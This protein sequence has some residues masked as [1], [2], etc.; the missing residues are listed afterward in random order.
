[1]ARSLLS[2]TDIGDRLREAFDPQYHCNLYNLLQ[3]SL[4]KDSGQL[5]WSNQ[6]N[7]HVPDF[8]N[9]VI[10][11]LTAGQSRRILQTMFTHLSRVG[12]AEP[13]PEFGKLNKWSAEL[14]KQIYLKRSMGNNQGL[15]AF[16]E[17]NAQA[18]NEG[19][20]LGLGFV[21]HMLKTN[22]KT[23]RQYVCLEHTPACT[24]F[25]DRHV[26]HPG[27]SDFICFTKYIRKDRAYERFGKSKVE[28]Y[29]HAYYGQEGRGT[30]P[31][32]AV[33]V[34]EY[35]DIGSESKLPTRAVIPE[36]FSNEPLEYEENVFELLPVSWHIHF[37]A[38]M[39]RRPIGRV[40]MQTADEEILNIMEGWMTYVL[41]RPAF[42]AVDLSSVDARSW[43]DYQ[44]G[45][46]HVV[47]ITGGDATKAIQRVPGMEL[48]ASFMELRNWYEQQFNADSGTTDYDRGGMPEGD[49]T[50]YE[51]GQAL[52]RSDIP[53]A[54]SR[55]QALAFYRRTTMT[56]L[57]L[58][59]RFDR[60]PVM[61]DVFG[62]DIL[63]NDPADPRI[64]LSEVLA[65]ESDVKISEDS[66]DIEASEM[67]RAK[68]LAELRELR[69]AGL[70]GTT[71]DPVWYTEEMLRAIGEKDPKEAMV[72]GLQQMQA[73]P[74]MGQPMMPPMAPLEAG[75]PPGGAP[76][77]QPAA[78]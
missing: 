35:Y 45:L 68:R 31:V 39:M 70:V 78:Y 17:E 1:M 71:V 65:E 3:R 53:K 42:D 30:Y 26:A 28:Q 22:W 5:V 76:P 63:V 24:T 72:P 10:D 60:D 67:R 29:V 13:E 38:P 46:S 56:L 18:F 9:I 21:Q 20:G 55:K 58:A 8:P 12:Y 23:G 50:K 7:D 33:K 57:E 51:V 14:R 48:P 75:M 44:R 73:Q 41:K 54:W 2:K 49:R 37:L 6:E 25:F 77:G 69:E 11:A 43:N 15:Y 36:F 16:S 62:Y 61:V 34:Y 52:A 64:W 47:G 66:I 32:E 74:P 19:D 27:A 4:G 40:I 59:K